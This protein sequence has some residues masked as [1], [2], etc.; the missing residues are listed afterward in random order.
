MR[1]NEQ[2]QSCGMPINSEELAGTAANG[3]LVYDY[4]KYCYQNGSFTQPD[5]TMEDMIRLSIPFLL[6]EGWEEEAARSMLSKTL[7]LL[8]R[9][10]AQEAEAPSSSIQPLKFVEKEAIT[11]AGKAVRTTNAAEMSGQGHIPSLWASF[12]Q[13]SKEIGPSGPIYGCYTDYENGVF[14]KYTYLLGHIVPPGD[15]I[16]DGLSSVTLPAARYAVFRTAHGPL[17]QVVAEAWQRIWQW[18]ASVQGLE[19]TF[20]GDFELYNEFAG[21]A[22]SGQ[23]DIY[24]AVRSTI[25]HH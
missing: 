16:P 10:A 21:N 15:K 7:P 24:I 1:T 23:A 12:L 14:G 20:S 18:S 22:A 3:S 11:L 5:I 6:Q 17:H 8:K 2:C 25:R 19:R 9:W 4:C 13:G